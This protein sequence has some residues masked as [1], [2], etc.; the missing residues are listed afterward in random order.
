MQDKQH[1]TGGSTNYRLSALRRNQLLLMQTFLS[2]GPRRIP[3]TS[4]K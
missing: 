2:K 3:H 4:H 1:T